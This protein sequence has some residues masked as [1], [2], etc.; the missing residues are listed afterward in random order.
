MEEQKVRYEPRRRG[1]VRT[2]DRL[3]SRPLQNHEQ[4]CL[5]AKVAVASEIVFARA[6]PRSEAG[7]TQNR[8]S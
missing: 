8:L 1:P 2:L 3:D 7:P 4:N 6:E 5:I